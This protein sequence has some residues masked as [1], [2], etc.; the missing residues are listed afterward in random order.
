MAGDGDRA[1]RP[2][3]RYISP[4]EKS[5]NFP[6][7]KPILFLLIAA[8]LSGLGIL[9]LGRGVP[10]QADLRVW[11]FDESHAASYRNPGPNGASLTRLYQQRT[12]Q[13]VEVKL[14]P[15]RALDAR[16]ISLFHAGRNG[17]EL[18]DVVEV[19]I[20]SVGKYF[21]GSPGSV[22]FLPLDRYLRQSGLDIRLVA[23]RLAPYTKDGVIF[24]I[25]ADVHPVTITYRRD[26]FDQ[27]G[28]DLASAQTWEQFHDRCLDFESYWRN[29]G[30][31]KRR[32]MELS[33]TGA[34]DL[35][36]LLLQRGVNLVD[37]AG[38]VHLADRRVASTLA[39]Y[40]QMV[41]GRRAIAEG[42][43]AG[44]LLWVRDLADGRLCAALTPD[45][46]IRYLREMAPELSGKLAM[47]PLPRFEPTDAPTS[48]WGGTMLGIP[49]N[50]ANP[51][52]AWALLDFLLASPEGLAARRE[53]TDILPPLRDVMASL[54]LNDPDPFFGGQRVAALYAELAR[55]VPANRMHAYTP[56]VSQ[57]LAD[58]LGQAIARVEAGQTQDLDQ[59]C[60]EML[61]QS[62]REL[63]SLIRFG[64]ARP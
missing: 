20:A 9:L 33:R 50:V 15:S 45:W 46:R 44:S 13:S 22:P 19:E 17:R 38:Q 36:M 2:T 1:L 62:Q 16:L 29:A 54:T 58:V 51:D 21:R 10:Q 11:V 39:F 63:E 40:A 34:S 37:E 53:H 24:G 4:R 27:A 64:E 23:N 7:G 56:L 8:I 55:Q 32:A 59:A 14:I 26:L 48:T 30:E 6:P 31:A 60:Q 25:P 42:A 49:R 28:V 52:A 43:A 3:F 61:A 12:G 5:M 35:M 47:M 18:P 41:A 57:A